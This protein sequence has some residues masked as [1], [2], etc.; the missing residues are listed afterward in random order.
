[1]QK[2]CSHSADLG[3]WLV[4]PAEKENILG[5][6]L[7]FFC[8]FCILFQ[9]RHSADSVEWLRVGQRLCRCREHNLGR[10]LRCICLLRACVCRCHSIAARSSQIASLVPLVYGPSLTCESRVAGGLD[11]GSI[12]VRL[13]EGR[14]RHK[15]LKPRLRLPCLTLDSHAQLGYVQSQ[16]KQIAN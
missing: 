6:V 11:R 12:A 3:G 1:M 5:V 4:F 16:P 10:K 15:P 8:Y 2:L 14:N 9:S 7:S 13:G